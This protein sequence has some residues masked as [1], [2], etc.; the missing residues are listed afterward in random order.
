MHT[1]STK[2]HPSIRLRVDSSSLADYVSAFGPGVAI[3]RVAPVP[4]WT[5][6]QD[7]NYNGRPVPPDGQQE[8]SVTASLHAA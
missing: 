8:R 7:H 5:A 6:V 3:P 1:D 4:A 2:G